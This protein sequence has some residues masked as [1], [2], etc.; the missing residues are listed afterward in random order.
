MG[1]NKDTVK[2]TKNGVSY[3]KFKA[4]EFIEELNKY[5][6]NKLEVVGRAN[7]NHWAGN[8]IP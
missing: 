8:I 6:D 4:K 1:A 7:I 2:I 5:D 3:M